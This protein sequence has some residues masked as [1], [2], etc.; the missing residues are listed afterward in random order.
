MDLDVTADAILAA[1]APPLVGFQQQR[2]FSRERIAAGV[3]RL[4]IEGL[5]TPREVGGGGRFGLPAPALSF[6]PAP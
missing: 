3:A 6:L 4:F 5:R 2:G 1:L